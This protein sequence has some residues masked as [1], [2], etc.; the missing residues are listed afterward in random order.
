MANE[1]LKRTP[2]SSGNRSVFTWS[3]WVKFGDINKNDQVLYSAVSGSAYV[4]FRFMGEDPTAS[5]SYKFNF[6]MYDG[7]TSYNIYTDRVLRD[8]GSW[9]HIFLSVD[10][11]QGIAG[12]RTKIYINNELTNQV[13][14]SG[15]GSPTI[16]AQNYQTYVNSSGAVNNI[17]YHSTYGEYSTCNIFDLCLVDGQALTPDVFGFYKD[18]DGYMSSGTTQATDFRPGQWSPRLPKS[19]K[20]TINRSGGF[21]VNGF[22]LPM[23]DSSNPGADFHCE[24]NSIIKLKGEDLPQPR[25][26]APTT[27]DAY[28]SQLRPEKE[29]TLGFDGCVR[30]D[31]TDDRLEIANNIDLELGSSDFCMEAFI[32]ASELKNAGIFGNNQSSPSP[33]GYEF[34]I[35]SSGAI[36][37]YSGNGS[38]YSNTGGNLGTISSAGVIK[39][40]RWHHVA[41]VRNG[42]TLR[43]YVDGNKVAEN[44]SFSHTIANTTN[45]H[46]IGC[47]GI[48][49]GSSFHFNGLISNARLVK[50]SPVYTANFTPP[51]EP[52]TAITN[53]KL[54]CCQSSTDATAATVTPGTIT[55]NGN[56]FATKNEILGSM[57]LAVPG[58]STATGAN[59]VTNGT[60]DTNTTGWTSQDATLSVDSGRIKVL[61]TNTNFGSA[62]QTVTGLTVGQRYTF[63]VDMFYG[64]ASMVTAISG[65]S[66][67][68]NSGWQG[69]NDYVWRAS[70]TAS[71]TSLV[72]D[73]QM[74][75]INAVYGFWDNAILKQEDA[76]RDYSAD[77]R[78]SGTNKT[79]TPDGGAGVGYELGGYYGSAMTFDGSGDYIDISESNNEYDLDGDYTIE[80]WVNFNSINNVNDIIG[81]ANN[82]VYLGSGKGGWIIGY[83]TFSNVGFRFGYQNNSSWVF[84]Y[85]TGITAV[86]NQ[87]Y[88][89]AISHSGSTQQII[90]NGV[91]VHT[92]TQT[93][94]LTSTDNVLRVGG[95]FGSTSGLLN[96]QIQDFRIYKGVAKYKGGFDVPKPYTPVGIEAFRTTDDTCK[97]NFAT[98]NPLGTGTDLTYSNG[99]LTCVHG[100]STTRGPSIATIGVTQ[101]GTEKYYWEYI[102]TSTN[103]NNALTGI[104]GLGPDITDGKYAGYTNQYG[105]GYYSANG[106]TYTA[107][108]GNLTFAA[109]GAS[110]GNGDVI[111]VALDME[112]NNGTLTFYKNGVSQG[113]A[114]TGLGVYLTSGAIHAWV[115]GF[116]DGGSGSNVTH[117]VN[118]GQNPSFSGTIAEGTNADDSGKGLFK[119][120]PPTGFL[121]L[122][123]DNLPTPAIADPGKHFKTV[124]YTGSSVSGSEK[125]R[126]VSGLGFKPDLVWLKSRGIIQNHQ[127]YDSVRGFGGGKGLSADENRVEGDIGGFSDTDYGFVSS[128]D[129][130]GFGVISTHSTGTWV[131]NTGVDYVAWCWKAGG[132]AVSNT[133][134][135]LASQVSANQ[136]A[137]FSIVSYT[138][139]QTSGAT[140]GHGLG[141]TPKMVIVK[142]RTG[143]TNNWTVYHAGAGN[144]IA[145]YL[146]L[147]NAN[148]DFL[149]A[150][151]DTS[152]TSSVFSLG[153]S[154]ETNRNSSPYIAYCWTEIE[155]FSKFGSYVGN[156]SADGPFVYCGFKPAFIMFKNVSA[157]GNW[158][159]SDS[160]RDSSNPVFGYQVADGSAIEETGTALFDSLSNG[161]K[162]RNAWTSFNGSNN[163]IIFMAFAES[164]FQT[165]NAK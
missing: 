86:A 107:Y 9:Y 20:Y 92:A 1:Y 163:T 103:T 26:G 65:A 78:G 139:N 147:P 111:G 74:A 80:F 105:I 99:N 64:N 90:I 28:V 25:N 123:E 158:V 143:N 51:T 63:Q 12:D 66:P 129:D 140:V 29:G 104:V 114:A 5:R 62:L 21:G 71:T 14:E 95:G 156:Q 108:G 52:L 162:I 109:Y 15:S 151:N 23:N 83:A 112:T 68:I 148:S 19:I 49:S 91:V 159:M 73:F 39:T 89:V 125:S 69:P 54:L 88:H 122:C 130:N 84:E 136:T 119:Y 100:S 121:A 76:P 33:S 13:A 131:N 46:Q 38:A 31:G 138:A 161:F 47:D 98:L 67:S 102:S 2:T 37:F 116:G 50:G 135:T 150:W 34:D 72:I 93:N 101:A 16:A 36:T 17:G 132:A 40:G 142:Q 41:A 115:P 45:T 43:L 60:F 18:G 85:S 53:T 58:I 110:Y 157:A 70:F 153:N 164:P 77:I 44:T 35:F 145:M 96:G 75:S 126:S 27:T 42:N 11:T 134:G 117:H 155:G 137:G 154:V 10:Y 32:F 79:L 146:D 113:V 97:N 56:T 8:P 30:F 152:P 128:A 124:L 7:S 127:L 59:L 57:V 87:W 141:K 118:F 55:T 22:Y 94:T 3:G 133:D 81:T 144:T 48:S 24:P 106:E 82:S 149:G 120:A 160:S 61:T 6:Q 165:A 4:H